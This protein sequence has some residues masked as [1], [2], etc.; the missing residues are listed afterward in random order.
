MLAKSH[1]K[2]ACKSLS[3]SWFSGEYAASMEPFN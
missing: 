3:D 2:T 1:V